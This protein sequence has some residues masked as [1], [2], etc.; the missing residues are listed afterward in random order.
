VGN[1]AGVRGVRRN[2]HVSGRRIRRRELR[3]GGARKS[4]RQLSSKVRFPPRPVAVPLLINVIP[5]NRFPD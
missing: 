4:L 2:R 3:E 1:A 5:I